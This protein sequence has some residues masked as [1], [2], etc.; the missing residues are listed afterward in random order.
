MQLQVV[1]SVPILGPAGY[2]SIRR[3]TLNFKLPYRWFWLLFSLKNSVGRTP[4]LCLGLKSNLNSD[5]CVS[6]VVSSLD[7]EVC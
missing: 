7:S 2:V 1:I 5:A 4:G 6:T 3:S